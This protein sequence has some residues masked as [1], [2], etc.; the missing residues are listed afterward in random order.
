MGRVFWGT[1]VLFVPELCGC[2]S[3]WSLGWWGYGL[4]RTGAEPE[5]L[6]RSPH[7]RDRGCPGLRLVISLL[8]MGLV[9]QPPSCTPGGKH[10]PG[11]LHRC[12]PQPGSCWRLCGL[13]TVTSMSLGLCTPG[14]SGSSCL[15]VLGAVLLHC[16]HSPSYAP[17]LPCQH[18]LM[19][20]WLW[21][22]P[23]EIAA[24]K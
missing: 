20:G 4:D 1:G 13:Y 10:H 17:L 14:G 19:Y 11:W 22:V 23:M 2:P 9:L 24:E 18:S 5:T 21:L 7:P 6:L 16:P 3:Y 8:A 15:V 12:R